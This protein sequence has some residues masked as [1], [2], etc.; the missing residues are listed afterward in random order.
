M[1]EVKSVHPIIVDMTTN[2]CLL[3]IEIYT[4]AAISIISQATYQKLF[5]EV[6]M[7]EVPLRL[8]TYTGEHIVVVSE[9]I[10][11]VQYGSQAKELG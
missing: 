3:K 7:N 6:P 9:M 2:G 4:G 1:M 5:S 10:T 8:K 11:Q